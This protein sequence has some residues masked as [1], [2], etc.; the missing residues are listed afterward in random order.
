MLTQLSVG[1]LNNF[2]ESYTSEYLEEKDVKLF[3]SWA[4]TWSKISKNF[5][6]FIN[7]NLKENIYTI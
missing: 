6:L 1:S 4:L 5:E 3:K 7:N 2:I